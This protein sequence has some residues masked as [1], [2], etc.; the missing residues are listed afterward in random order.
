[1]SFFRIFSLTFCL[2]L[3]LQVQQLMAAEVT[4]NSEFKAGYSGTN[5]QSLTDVTPCIDSFCTYIWNYT[6]YKTIL[7]DSRINH[8]FVRYSNYARDNLYLKFPS[9]RKVILQHEG[10]TQTEVTFKIKRIGGT[11]VSQA[12][13]NSLYK[14]IGKGGIGIMPST[15]T[16]GNCSSVLAGTTSR[17]NTTS[18]LWDI[19]SPYDNI[20]GN[21]YRLLTKNDVLPNSQ[22][23]TMEQ[24]QIAFTYE[25]LTDSPMKLENGKYKGRLIFSVGSGA[26]FDMGEGDYADPQL[27][28]NINLNVEHQAMLRFPANSTKVVMEPEKGWQGYLATGK[29]TESVKANIPFQIWSTGP[30]NIYLQCSVDM[31]P[32]CGLRN[33]K[34]G[35]RITVMTTITMPQG[36]KAPYGITADGIRL[37]AAPSRVKF[38]PDQKISNGAGVVHFEISSKEVSE[39]MRSNPGGEYLGSVSLMIEPRL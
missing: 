39:A 5:Q 21:C 34:N 8:K 4:I 26:D 6:H 20:G 22:T 17:G 14:M 2:L 10:G 3:A 31:P 28:V 9:S 24:T 1:M 13:Q 7:V 25:L 30:L 32:Y 12:G 38:T 19:N 16:N 37:F 23:F 15:N 33:W 27:I 18:F 29:M 36:M 35:H 11:Y